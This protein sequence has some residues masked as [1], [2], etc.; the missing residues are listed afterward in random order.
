MLSNPR[1]GARVKIHYRAGVRE[2]MP[3][4]GKVATV[5]IPCKA[6]RCRNHGVRL[7]ATGELVAVPAGN[8]IPACRVA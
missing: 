4:Q 5:V 3:H 2:H 1:P 6:R 8:L 7:E